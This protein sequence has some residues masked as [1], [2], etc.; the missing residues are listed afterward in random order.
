VEEIRRIP[1]VSLSTDIIVGFPGETAGQF[2]NTLNL[3][4]RT[5]F[6]AVHVAAYSPRPGT[7]ASR[8]MKDDVPAGEKKRRLLEVEIVQEAIAGEINRELVGQDVEVL[9]ESRKKDKWEG[10]TR[11]NKL[12]FFPCNDHNMGEPRGKVVTVQI[13]KATA[14]SLQGKIVDHG[15]K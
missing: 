8:T 2:Q 10:R 3:L 7:V 4:S 5:R 9:V 11:S 13:E 14:W 15:P 1:H 12:V 6:D